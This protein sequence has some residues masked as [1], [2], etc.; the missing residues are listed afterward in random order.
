MIQVA[1]CALVVRTYPVS[2]ITT[3]EEQWAVLC[4]FEWH[5]VL[6]GVY[7]TTVIVIQLC[8]TLYVEVVELGAHVSSEEATDNIVVVVAMKEKILIVC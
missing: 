1:G 7:L 8:H 3:L 6:I 5:P 4:A 2:N